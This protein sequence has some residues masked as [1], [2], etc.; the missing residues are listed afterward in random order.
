[1]LMDI[2]SAVAAAVAYT[3]L[4]L[5]LLVLGVWVLDLLTP[6]KLSHLIWEERSVNAT[7]VTAASIAGLAAVVFTALWT[8]S[9]GGPGTGL[10]WTLA[11]GLLGIVLQL[12][13]FLVVD[14]LTPGRLGDT[15]AGR[16]FHPAS[17]VVAVTSLATSA[18]VVAAIA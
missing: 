14:W 13:A 6:G 17:V 8:T 7:V 5:I 18:V 11:F 16:E 1:M 2:G 12:L 9:G 3:V 4:G 15:I 10:P